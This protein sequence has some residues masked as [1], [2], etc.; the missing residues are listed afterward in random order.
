[1]TAPTRRTCA[2]CDRCNAAAGSERRGTLRTASSV[3]RCV[4][5]SLTLQDQLLQR[6]IRYGFA[7]PLVLILEVIQ[8]FDLVGLQ[9]AELLAPSIVGE[10]RDADRADRL[11]HRAALREQHVHLPQLGDDLSRLVLLL[12]RSRVL[13]RLKSLLQGGPLSWGQTSGTSRSSATSCQS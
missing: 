2:R 7:Q 12:Y 5:Q 9:T 6:Q 11:R 4:G 10:R 3:S 1:M 8:P 13:Q